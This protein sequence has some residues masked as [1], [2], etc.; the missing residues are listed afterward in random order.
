MDGPDRE[1]GRAGGDAVAER[2]RRQVRAQVVVAIAQRR[3]VERG[4]G[5]EPLA[6]R[7]ARR[8]RLLGAPPRPRHRGELGLEPRVDPGGEP[9]AR[10]PFHLEERLELPWYRRPALDLVELGG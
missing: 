5:G 9:L 6:Q 10:P 7:R 8:Q 1:T 2:G 3:A 4:D